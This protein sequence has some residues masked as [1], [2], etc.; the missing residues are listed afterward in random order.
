MNSQLFN[1]ILN[2][3]LKSISLVLGEK[4]KEYAIGDRLY[5]FKRAAEILRTTP[6]KAL[7]GMMAKHLVSVFDLIEGN[8]RPSIGMIDEKIGDAINYLILLEA[9]LKENNLAV[10]SEKPADTRD[11]LSVIDNIINI[12]PANEKKFISAIKKVRL[13]SSYT[14]PEDMARRWMQLGIVFNEYVPFPSV[15]E[16]H[17]IAIKIFTDKGNN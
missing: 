14:A 10:S 11:I 2:R 5:N 7:L 1:E 13:D 3:R 4:A 8:L 9:I 6:E 17:K 15:R 12:I 16:W